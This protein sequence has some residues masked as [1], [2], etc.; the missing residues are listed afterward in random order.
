M[1]IKTFVSSQVTLYL[2][3]VVAAQI[4]FLLRFVLP[5]LA[6]GES[7]VWVIGPASIVVVAG[8]VAIFIH[9]RFC[10]VV[11]TDGETLIR[12][13]GIG[14][15]CVFYR[16][17]SKFDQVSRRRLRLSSAD[18]TVVFTP[19]ITGFSYLK[20]LARDWGA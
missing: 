14:I 16:G 5:G 4:G 20:S 7:V 19:D 8:V 12:V 1:K 10:F 6:A 11:R 18:G 13:W 2:G 15:D 17:S 3:M 9:R